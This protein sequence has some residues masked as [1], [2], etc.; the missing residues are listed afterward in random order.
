MTSVASA[1]T[2]SKDTSVQPVMF[3]A[4]GATLAGNLYHPAGATE[5]D[6]LPGVVV[7]GTWTSVKEQMANRYAERLAQRRLVALS[8]DLTGLWPL[9]RRAS[10]GR[11]ARPQGARHRVGGLVAA[12]ASGDR[13][14]TGRRA[15]DLRQRGLCGQRVDPR[16]APASARV[17]R[18]L[19]ARPPGGDAAI[20][21][22]ARRFYEG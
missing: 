3:R 18:S 1:S 13:C 14:R 8:F 17:D 11:V 22:G 19:A 21:H 2:L 15:R 10:R 6:P 9:R 20:P 12:P 4:G 16:R 7:P 5:A